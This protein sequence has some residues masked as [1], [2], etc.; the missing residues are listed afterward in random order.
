MSL[1]EATIQRATFMG[2]SDALHVAIATNN[3]EV[4]DGVVTR[5]HDMLLAGWIDKAQ[6]AELARD[7]ANHRL[8]LGA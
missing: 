7:A 8:H 5:A 1:L 2:L 4:R 3:T 6:A